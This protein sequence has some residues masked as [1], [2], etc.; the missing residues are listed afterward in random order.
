[1]SSDNKN[2]NGVHLL[3]AYLLALESEIKLFHWYTKSYTRHKISDKLSKRAF[4]AIDKFVELF[5]VSTSSS[6]STP[7]PSVSPSVRRKN[8]TTSS[9]T[10]SENK[11]NSGTSE[12]QSEADKITK[13]LVGGDNG[14]TATLPIELRLLTRD[15]KNNGDGTYGDANDADAGASGKMSS[16]FQYALEEALHVLVTGFGGQIIKGNAAL[17]SQRDTIAEE[18]THA[19]Y[20]LS[21]GP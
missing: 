1:M 4:P 18:L 8:A 6:S 14:K 10:E 19:L 2:M 20:Y 7:T 5:I 9:S 11:E 21:K 13:M 3:V 16:D 12:P 17:E 15:E